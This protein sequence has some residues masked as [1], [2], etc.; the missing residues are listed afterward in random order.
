MPRRVP[1]DSAKE[2]PAVWLGAKGLFRWPFDARFEAWGLAFL[3]TPLS[4]VAL[5]YVVPY[6][7]VVAV[8][9]VALGRGVG[10]VAPG[11]AA[12]KRASIAALASLL[13]IA[14]LRFGGPASLLLPM[15]WLLA[16]LVAPIVAV[17][18][19]RRI[20]RLVDHNRPLRY[21]IA[22]FFGRAKA[23]RRRRDIAEFIPQ[24]APHA[25]PI[26]LLADD[27]DPLDLEQFRTHLNF[28]K[29]MSLRK[30]PRPTTALV[31]QE[32]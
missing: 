32:S 31:T 27:P 15:H 16:G 22:V 21:R 11:Q 14:A 1:D 28:R 8:A 7:A 20:M 29:P 9:A 12:V 18:L 10:R 5:T 2:L 3:L 19:T 4:W 24:D 30:A 26:D 6:P 23:P 17:L 13:V 25:S